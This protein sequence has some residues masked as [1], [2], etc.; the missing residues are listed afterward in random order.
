MNATVAKNAFYLSAASVA[1]KLLSFVYFTYISNLLGAG[2]QGKYSFALAFTTIFSIVADLGLTPV[3]IREI[4]RARERTREILH[5]VLGVKIILVLCA[6]ALAVF[7]AIGLKHYSP[8]EIILI[9]AAGAVMMFDSVHLTVYGVFRAHQN[10]KVEAVGVV[11]GQTLTLGFGA[12]ALFLHW[13]LVTLIAALAGGS[14]FNVL[15][16]TWSLWH[17]QKISLFGVGRMAILPT[18]VKEAVPFA[19]AGIFTRVY[20]GLDSVLLRTL[21]DSR[22][23]GLYSVPYKIAFAFQFIPMAV[24]AAL[25]PAMSECFARDK[26]RLAHLFERATFTLSLIVFPVAVGISV[27]AKEIL[28]FAFLP[29]YGVAAS[30]L[31]FLMAALIFSFLDFP[32][33]SLLNACNRQHAQTLAMGATMVVNLIANLFFIPRWGITGAAAAAC[34]T[35]AIASCGLA[36]TWR[37]YG[38]DGRCGFIGEALYACSGCRPD[39]RA[40]L[41]RDDSCSAGSFLAEVGC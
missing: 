30:A 8:E 29:E 1:Q 18:I 19:L 15:W 40:D 24:S 33:G 5:T 14:L 16:S 2:E 17:W 3:M 26:T 36:Q 39:W 7:F 31:I 20:S 25:Y 27:L 12:V 4:S 34:D 41:W 37:R 11:I 38:S 9:V 32:V 13:P 35:M 23:V 28:A 22:A 10:L 21:N 6:Y